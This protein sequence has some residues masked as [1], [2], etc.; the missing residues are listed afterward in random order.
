M[1]FKNCLLILMNILNLNEFGLS[2]LYIDCKMKFLVIF[3]K[4]MLKKY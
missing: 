3:I 4:W 1:L 2:I